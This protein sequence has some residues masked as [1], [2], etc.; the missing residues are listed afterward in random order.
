V[1]FTSAS[2]AQAFVAA[3]GEDVATRLPAASIGPITTAAARTAGFDVQLEAGQSTI[4]G[5]VDAI[6]RHY[7]G[8]PA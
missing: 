2:A 1:T 7:A 8:S 4:A 3:V 5:L 6:E